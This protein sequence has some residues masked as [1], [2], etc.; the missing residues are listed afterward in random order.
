MGRLDA[1]GQV[2]HGA[3]ASYDDQCITGLDIEPFGDARIGFLLLEEQQPVAWYAAAIAHDLRNAL[4]K[5][6]ADQRPLDDRN[7][8]IGAAGAAPFNETFEGEP[9]DRLAH[10]HAADAEAF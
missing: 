10:G 2:V 3:Q 8:D 6:P 4:R 5:H 9:V 1:E 7:R